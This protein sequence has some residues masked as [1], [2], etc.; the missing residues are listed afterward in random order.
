MGLN[1]SILAP[2]PDDSSLSELPSQITKL[3]ASINSERMIR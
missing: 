3:E 1:R 2:L